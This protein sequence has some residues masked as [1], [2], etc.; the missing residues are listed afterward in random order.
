M[1]V[2]LSV[3]KKCKNGGFVRDGVA[4]ELMLDRDDSY[5]ELLDKAREVL[6]MPEVP[7]GHF[8]TLLSSGGAVIPK[9]VGW[10]VGGYLRQMHKGPAQARLGLGV[11]KQVGV[12]Y[13]YC[14]CKSSCAII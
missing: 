1:Q 11:M 10:T 7:H 6:N 5:D 13:M 3:M 14:I 8:V 2:T 9:R 4:V 12:L